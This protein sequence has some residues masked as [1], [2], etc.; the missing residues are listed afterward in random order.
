[1]IGS[2]SPD[3]RALRS[4]LIASTTAFVVITFHLPQ[5]FLAVLAAVLLSPLRMD[6]VSGLAERLFAAAAGVAAGFLAA[7][8]APQA[9]WISVPLFGFF[10]VFGYRAFYRWRGVATSL[11]FVMGVGG[12]FPAMWIIGPPGIETALAHAM[13]LWCAA[14][15]AAFWCM[16]IPFPVMQ[17]TPPH[18]PHAIQAGCGAVTTIL[19]S[20]IALPG[21]AVVM[22][23]AALTGTLSLE[24]AK[25]K[26]T[27]VA[28]HLLGVFV[29]IVVSAGFLVL[30]VSN[31]NDPAIFLIGFGFCFYGFERL[32]TG[33][34]VIFWRRVAIVFAVCSTMGPAPDVGFFASA[35]RFMAI[36]CG[37]GISAVFF[38]F[39]PT[40]QQS[41]QESESDS[42]GNHQHP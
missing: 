10:C 28:L 33:R 21:E 36:L 6:G 2:E 31:S 26:A 17:R 4:A 41:G 12:A 29:G 15:S 32:A 42:N 19:L 38:L 13:A 11:L 35:D 25:E 7:V 18:E 3:R 14:A 39:A 37:F 27:E 20:A 8:L 40:P 30:F 24:N 5:P 23:I 9:P 34:G 1:M 16:A 22:T